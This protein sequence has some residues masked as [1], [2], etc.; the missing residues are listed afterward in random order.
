MV[1]CPFEANGTSVADK[2]KAG[3]MESMHTTAAT[4]MGMDG[5]G[6]PILQH[7]S[8]KVNQSS[9]VQDYVV[10]FG[11]NYEL[12]VIKAATPQNKAVGDMFEGALE[13]MMGLAAAVIL[14]GG[15]GANVTICMEKTLTH[16]CKYIPEQGF[17][18]GFDTLTK[19]EL[20]I[21]IVL[22][23]LTPFGATLGE[24]A[25][26]AYG[27]FPKAVALG[28]KAAAFHAVAT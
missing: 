1:E 15:D 24:G 25:G 28:E 22:Q 11:P 10:S 8:L 17:V 16:L 14:S 13:D 23:A 6:L 7:G 27:K 5:C 4:A 26:A 3:K 19:A 20:V 2:L 18:N 12:L 9:A 21:L